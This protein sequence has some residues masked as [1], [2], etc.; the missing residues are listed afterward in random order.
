M[1]RVLER[2]LPLEVQLAKARLMQRLART[3]TRRP[4]KV[5]EGAAAYEKVAQVTM[6]EHGRHF[7]GPGCAS[8]RSAMLRAAVRYVEQP[9]CR[10]FGLQADQG[11]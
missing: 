2:A 5:A 8:L 1:A 11:L 3:L 7:R 9:A 4:P 6:G 10:R